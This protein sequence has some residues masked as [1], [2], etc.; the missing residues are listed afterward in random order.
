MWDMYSALCWA[1]SDSSM[2]ISARV[3]GAELSMELQ[4]HGS[5]SHLQQSTSANPGPQ[6]S[7]GPHIPPRSHFSSQI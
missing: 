3:E 6:Q 5:R 7:T 2:N 1:Y 4:W